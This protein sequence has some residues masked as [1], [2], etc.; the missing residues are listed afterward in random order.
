MF[1]CDSS[2]HILGVLTWFKQ[3]LLPKTKI[4]TNV[5]VTMV[6]DHKLLSLVSE[7]MLFKEIL[8]NTVIE[9]IK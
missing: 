9:G 6:F 5:S 1:G 2:L 8:D 4:V 3:I 7:E